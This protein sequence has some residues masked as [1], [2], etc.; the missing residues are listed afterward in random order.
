MVLQ[1]S[2]VVAAAFSAEVASSSFLSINERVLNITGAT[3]VVIQD[4]SFRI[5]NYTSVAGNFTPNL[6]GFG[7]S[8]WTASSTNITVVT[9]II[10]QGLVPYMPTGLQLDGVAQ[11]IRWQGGVTPVGIGNKINIVAFTIMKLSNTPTYLVLG[12]MVSFG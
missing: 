2:V 6:S 11:T 10:N 5:Y 1:N 12:Q 9:M 8:G 4:G 7:L 3:G